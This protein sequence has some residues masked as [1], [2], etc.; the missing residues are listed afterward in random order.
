MC[1]QVADG[2]SNRSN[3]LQQPLA[4][5]D[6]PLT[7]ADRLLAL[8]QGFLHFGCDLICAQPWGWPFDHSRALPKLKVIADI[9]ARFTEQFGYVHGLAIILGL[10]LV[11]ALDGASQAK[12]VDA[13][14]CHSTW[15]IAAYLAMTKWYS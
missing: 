6:H 11:A 8:D 12:K 3:P 9:A 5:G 15:S 14:P 2:L 4:L 10:E 1:S 13:I 7:V